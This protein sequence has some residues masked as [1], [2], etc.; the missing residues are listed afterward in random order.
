VLD[1]QRIEQT[2]HDVYA[3]VELQTNSQFFK[4]RER[5]HA[6]ARPSDFLFWP[7]PR[8]QFEE[9]AVT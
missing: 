5:L 1:W 7:L 8:E 2:A 3:N 4:G 6:L 9:R